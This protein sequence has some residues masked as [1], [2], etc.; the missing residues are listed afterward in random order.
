VRRGTRCNDL[1]ASW[2]A[3]R[4]GAE[5]STADEDALQAWIAESTAHRVA[6]LRL[7]ETWGRAD[8]LAALRKPL[9]E[10]SPAAA[11]S[12][13]P[14]RRGAWGTLT[15]R[16]A[17]GVAL[18]GVVGVLFVVVSGLRDES[19]FVTEV[20]GRELV[21]LNDGSRLTLNTDSRVRAVVGDD[22]RMVWLERGEVYF[23][24]AHDRTR[25]FVVLAGAQR[26]T[27]LGTRFSIRNQDGHVSVLVEEGR[28]QV[29]T[30]GVDLHP[31]KSTVVT[32]DDAVV[33]SAG[34]LAVAHRTPEQVSGALSWREGKIVLDQL[35]LGEAADEFN[36]YNRRKL[37][38]ADASAAQMR[39]GGT[40]DASN[41]ESFARLLNTG[42]GLSVRESADEI[43]I[44]H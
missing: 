24:V 28:V 40:F 4:D 39:I 16:I 9:G 41:V 25:P 6:Y 44:S 7:A 32:R 8:R 2:I 21:S 29:E 33:A 27:V 34:E 23:D 17:A 11:S 35:T 15:Q 12:S 3:R 43:D 26:I 18:A 5:W 36:R 10:A 1:A 37:V 14:A 42:F 22:K 19:R 30:L 20:G 31:L 13:W 38:I